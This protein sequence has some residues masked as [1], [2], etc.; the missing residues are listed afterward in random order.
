ML[1]LSFEDQISRYIELYCWNYTCDELQEYE[2][3]EV[4]ANYLTIL[5]HCVGHCFQHVG[6]LARVDR[7]HHCIFHEWELLDG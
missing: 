1:K 3:G 6:M 4:G 2:Q 5:P 7:R